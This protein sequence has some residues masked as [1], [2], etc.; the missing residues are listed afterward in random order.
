MSNITESLG[1][2]I[3]A[4]N[5]FVKAAIYGFLL[6][7]VAAFA[8][9]IVSTVRVLL[10]LFVLHIANAVTSTVNLANLPVTKGGWKGLNFCYRPKHVG[11][12]ETWKDGT[13]G[14][15]MAKLKFTKVPYTG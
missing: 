7:G 1:I 10:S 14:F 6:V 12:H 4:D 3:D 13:I 5:S 2:H 9:P 11:L 15:E 8:A